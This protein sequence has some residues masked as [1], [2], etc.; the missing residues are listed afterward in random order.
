[1]KKSPEITGP[2]CSHCHKQMEWQSVQLVA[3]Q[4]MNIF[5]CAVC[6]RIAAAIAATSESISL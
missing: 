3:M 5:H 2:E 1:M 6:D 4:P